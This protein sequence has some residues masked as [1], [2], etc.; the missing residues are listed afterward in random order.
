M[1]QLYNELVT[2]VDKSTL[3]WI[4]RYG[5]GQGIGLCLTEAPV[6][7]KEGS[8]DIIKEMCQTLRVHL[9]DRKKTEFMIGNTFLISENKV[10][11]LTG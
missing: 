9:K 10:E 5:L 8:G 4:P 3:E 1:A 2:E 6:M 11:I 7:V